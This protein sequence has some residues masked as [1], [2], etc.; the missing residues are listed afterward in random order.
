[1]EGF[2]FSSPQQQ[3]S[4]SEG[5][6]SPLFLRVPSVGEG[7]LGEAAHASESGRQEG[8]AGVVS[9]HSCYRNLP[10]WQ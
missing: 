2:Y 3:V 7:G 8:A 4:I 9:A 10:F 1:M 5:R 6:V